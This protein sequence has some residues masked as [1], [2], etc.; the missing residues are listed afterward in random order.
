V[1]A[2]FAAADVALSVKLGCGP[3]VVTAF[4]TLAVAGAAAAV[5]VVELVPKTL[6]VL[7]P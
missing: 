5:A 2:G 3:V 4:E 6:T 7:P 1:G